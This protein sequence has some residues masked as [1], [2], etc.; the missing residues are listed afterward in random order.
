MG[1]TPTKLLAEKLIGE[2]ELILGFLTDE[3]LGVLEI[4]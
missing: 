3:D 2:K 1:N 4:Y